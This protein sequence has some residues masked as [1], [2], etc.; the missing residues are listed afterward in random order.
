MKLLCPNDILPQENS[1]ARENV[2]IHGVN[3]ARQDFNS[4]REQNASN[5]NVSLPRVVK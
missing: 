1:Q 3:R 2:G 5:F 4:D